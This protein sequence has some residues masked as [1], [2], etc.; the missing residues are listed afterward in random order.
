MNRK[1]YLKDIEESN[2][3]E[4]FDWFCNLEDIWIAHF[5]NNGKGSLDDEYEKGRIDCRFLI[6]EIKKE[7][8]KKLKGLN[9]NWTKIKYTTLSG[10]ESEVL[11]CWKIK[12][13]TRISP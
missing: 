3:D 13:A 6:N 11:D 5:E 10:Q 1:E 8:Y 7:F 4:L 12:K 9:E 2:L